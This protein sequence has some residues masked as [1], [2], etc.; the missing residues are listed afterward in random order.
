MAFR[1]INRQQSVPDSPE[2]LI[3]ELPRRN[4]ESALW[5]QGE[6]MH[7]YAQ[8]TALDKPDVAIQLPTGSGKTLVGLMI[9]EWR[10]RKFNERILYLCPT[11]QLVHQVVEQAKDQYGLNVNGYTGNWRN[12]KPIQKTQY[13][14]AER[15]AVTTYSSL[16]N[17]S[18]YFRNPQTI[19]IDDAHVA[20]NYIASLWSLHI[21]KDNPDHSSL[22]TALCNLLKSYLN[23][24]DYKRLSGVSDNIVDATWVDKVPTPTFFE[25]RNEFI[26]VVDTHV[27]GLSIQHEWSMLKTSLQGCHLYVSSKDILLRPIIPP[28]WSHK[29]FANAKQRIFMS[30]TLGAGGDLERLTGRKNIHRL[31]VPEGYNE[32][33]IGRRFFIFPTLSLDDSD[34]P[35]LRKDMMEKAGRSV[36]LVPSDRKREEVVQNIDHNEFKVFDANQ[37]EHSKMPFVDSEKAAAV[38]ANRYDGI[39]FPGDDC[40]VLF[41][42]EFPRATNSQENFLMAKMGANVMFNERLQTRVLQAI[43]RCTRSLKDYSAVIISGMHLPE[44]L[45]LDKRCYFHPELQ[46]ELDFGIEQ[47]KQSTAIEMLE[48]LE[49]F[50]ENGEKWEEANEEIL[51]LR[52]QATTTCFPALDDLFSSV[53]K[54]IEY[55]KAIFEGD[56]VNAHAA[57][58]S[59]LG[60]LN[61]PE[62]KGYRALWY[63]LAGSACWLSYKENN[64]VGKENQARNYF[65]KAKE[66]TSGVAWLSKLSAFTLESQE[67]DTKNLKINKQIEH[68]ESMLIDLGTVHMRKFET[69]ERE[70][71]DGL[72]DV[73]KFERAQKLL[74]DMIGFKTGKEESEGAPDPWWIIDDLCFVFEDHAGAETNSELSTKK[75]RQVSSHPNWIRHN[76][77][78]T[79]E[80]EVIPVLISPVS[81]ASKGAVPHLNDFYYWELNNFINWA[82]DALAA[83]RKLRKTFSESGNLVWR[84]EAQSILI[85]AGIDIVSIKKLV[86]ENIASKCLNHESQKNKNVAD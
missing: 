77:S 20:E 42:D 14:N 45:H 52:K 40:R 50:L 67:I 83:I 68:I 15:V 3:F 62:L 58:E 38:M 13:E 25:F 19:I 84:M 2:K 86:K 85:E 30:A 5:H 31:P 41:I 79:E 49:I 72:S 36:F 54:E 74:G 1:K 53:N 44:L 21:E 82:K 4:I 59:V 64:V 7:A 9:A 37:I 8:T 78:V 6:I 26:N 39:D 60:N 12:Y 11:K 47:S 18:P 43:G 69:R 61:A 70:I 57:A 81:K 51:R 66:A 32:Q 27:N 48:N 16:F 76:L 73:K 65:E 63:Y 24:L 10:R 17:T 22:H 33:G 35:S 56:F 23:T 46:A 34:I 55:Q 71:L 28:T 75:A 29:P 80:T